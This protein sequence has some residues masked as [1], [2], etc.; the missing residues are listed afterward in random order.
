MNRF[1]LPEHSTVDLNRTLEQ[2]IVLSHKRKG[3]EKG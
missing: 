2:R 1:F 3:E